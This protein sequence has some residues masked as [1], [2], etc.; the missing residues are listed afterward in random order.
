MKWLIGRVGAWAAEAGWGAA[1]GGGAETGE[2]GTDAGG[3]AKVSAPQS[4]TCAC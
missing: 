1:S 2:G 4:H 3:A